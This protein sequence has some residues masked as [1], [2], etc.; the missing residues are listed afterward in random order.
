[1]TGRVVMNGLFAN[2]TQQVGPKQLGE[3]S[4]EAPGALD[5]SI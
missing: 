5:V 1:M 4:G 3:A 2:G